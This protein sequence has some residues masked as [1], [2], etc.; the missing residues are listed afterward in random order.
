MTTESSSINVTGNILPSPVNAHMVML[1]LQHYISHCMF[2]L[3]SQDAKNMSSLDEGNN[4]MNKGFFIFYV[5]MESIILVFGTIG[6]V[7]VVLVVVKRHRMRTVTNYFILNL[8]IS[9]LIV[10]ISNIPI[11]FTM[12]FMKKWVFGKVMCLIIRP[13]QTLGTTA[14]ILTLVAICLSR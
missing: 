11:D 2:S 1:R 6:N 10:L 8:A 5:V 4:A 3:F 13:L 9:D 14:S 7:L 12:D